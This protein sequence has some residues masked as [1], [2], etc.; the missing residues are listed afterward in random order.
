MSVD[1][2]KPFYI[3]TAIDYANGA[4]HLGHTLEKVGA[5]VVAQYHRRK[6]EAVHYLIGMDEHGLNVLQS[7]QEAELSPQEWVDEIADQFLAAWDVLNISND[8][9][10]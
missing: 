2:K 9:K 5:D 1:R 10:N 8:D 7:A 3:T 4:P 6:G